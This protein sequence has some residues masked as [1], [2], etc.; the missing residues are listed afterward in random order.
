M[1]DELG[2]VHPRR[3]MP[4]VLKKRP[5]GYPA[6]VEQPDASVKRR[7]QH[8]MIIRRMPPDAV[9]CL[10]V[11]IFDSFNGKVS[12]AAPAAATAAAACAGRSQVDNLESSIVACASKRV[13][14]AE[15]NTLDDAF[16]CIRERRYTP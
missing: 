15:P 2:V 14:V 7:A 12:A 13:R 3:D 4:G 11:R 6:E 16:V 10:V 8:E 9:D 5:R 1:V